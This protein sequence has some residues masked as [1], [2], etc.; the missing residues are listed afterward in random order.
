M[1]KY[2]REVWINIERMNKCWIKDGRKDGWMKDGR[3]MNGWIMEWIWIYLMHI[4]NVDPSGCKTYIETTWWKIDRKI[5]SRFS[6]K[7][8]KYVYFYG[9]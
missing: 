8:G 6:Q 1:D 5:E 4:S 7:M 3:I 9:N 2:W